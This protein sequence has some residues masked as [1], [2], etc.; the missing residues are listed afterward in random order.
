[1]NSTVM[2]R[3]RALALAGTALLSWSPAIRAIAGARPDPAHEAATFVRK[4]ADRAIAMLTDRSLSAGDRD[5]ALRELLRTGFDLDIT[6]RLVL[7]RYW[8]QA[9]AEQRTAYRQLFED[10]LVATYG[11]QLREYSGQTLQVQGARLEGGRDAIVRSRVQASNGGSLI[12]V[13]WRLR[14]S[15]DRWRII[16][17]VVAGVSLAI[18]HRSEFAALISREGGIDG[19]LQALRRKTGS[20]QVAKNPDTTEART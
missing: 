5:E 3:R 15:Q 19:L 11:G 10:Y 18:T 12:G 1:M 6:S 16:D 7:G 8:G 17:V 20:G 2:P 9:T 4:F 13:D 14:R